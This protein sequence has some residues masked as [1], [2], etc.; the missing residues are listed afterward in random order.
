MVWLR[1]IKAAI[2]IPF[3]EDY[4][5]IKNYHRHLNFSKDELHRYMHIPDSIDI[6]TTPKTRL[7]NK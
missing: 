4:L 6:G 3:C 5:L 2:G 1:W 7:Y